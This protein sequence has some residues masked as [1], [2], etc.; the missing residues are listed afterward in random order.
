MT[1]EN[2]TA[3]WMDDPT[4]AMAAFNFL[5]RRLNFGELND[6]QMLALEQLAKNWRCERVPLPLSP[7]PA[8]QQSGGKQQSSAHSSSTASSERAPHLSSTSASKFVAADNQ[9][10]DPALDIDPA[11]GPNLRL[12]RRLPQKDAS[13][14]HLTRRRRLCSDDNDDSN[15]N[16]GG[17]RMN[18]VR[19]QRISLAVCGRTLI[20]RFV[21]D[22]STDSG[23]L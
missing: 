4:K 16:P 12:K 6:A 3:T 21:T 20:S 7:R 23:L 15:T 13:N 9:N 10:S 19:P 1:H 8:H 5:S 22:C 18:E 2:T 17:V 14:P 11:A